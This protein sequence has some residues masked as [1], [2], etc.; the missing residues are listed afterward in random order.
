[1]S[2]PQP[3]MLS[4]EEGTETLF[5]KQPGYISASCH[6]SKDGRRVVNYGQWRSPKDI[7]A[8][9]MKPEIGE[10]LKRVKSLAQFETI[11]CEASYVHRA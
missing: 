9:G 5:S 3:C 4:L 6:K 11:V 1:M 2:T 10:Y 8:F 7:E